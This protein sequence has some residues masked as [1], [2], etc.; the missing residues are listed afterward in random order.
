MNLFD[1]I[2]VAG[3]YAG[4]DGKLQE[5]LAGTDKTQFALEA[6]RRLHEAVPKEDKPVQMPA[7]PIPN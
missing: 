5:G 6:A 3:K 4:R 7:P 1:H 2:A